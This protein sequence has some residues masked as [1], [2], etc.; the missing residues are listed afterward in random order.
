LRQN[1]GVILVESSSG[2]ASTVYGVAEHAAILEQMAKLLGSL[3][4]EAAGASPA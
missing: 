3:A 2:Y 4:G 1:R